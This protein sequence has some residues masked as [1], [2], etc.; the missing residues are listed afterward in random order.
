VAVLLAAGVLRP[1]DGGGVPEG[2]AAEPRV[3]TQPALATAGVAQGPANPA[4]AANPT[5]AGPVA[6]SSPGNHP[7]AEAMLAELRR[8]HR[9]LERD[10]RELRELA[11][12]S[13]VIYIG[14]DETLDFVLDLGSDPPP[15][16]GPSVRPATLQR[17]G[18]GGGLRR[19]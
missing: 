16:G 14:G 17:P 19:F 4:A 12:G 18:P 6:A 5:K 3:S 2:S 9:G 15:G 10:L 13:Q 11:Q 1:V 8:E 7:E